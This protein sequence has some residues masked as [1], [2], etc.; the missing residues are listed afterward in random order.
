MVNIYFTYVIQINA[1]IST[2]MV[3]CVGLSRYIAI[4]TSAIIAVF[5][6][7][8]RQFLTLSALPSRALLTVCIRAITIV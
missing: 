3:C 7:Y 6:E 8:L 4:T 2:V 1:N 5:L